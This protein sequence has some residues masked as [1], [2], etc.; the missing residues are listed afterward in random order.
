[1][2]EIPA[3][4]EAVK[5]KAQQLELIQKKY[6]GNQTLRLGVGRKRGKKREADCFEHSDIKFQFK[7]NSGISASISDL[8][9][10]WFMKTTQVLSQSKGAHCSPSLKH[11]HTLDHAMP[12]LREIQCL[13]SP[14]R[15]S[16][17]SLELLELWWG[18]LFHGK[19][20]Q[21]AV[22]VSLALFY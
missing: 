8:S 3:A 1:M 6:S 21:E 5:P 16:A 14:V 22:L 13:V 12:I 20:G 11:T 9:A 19:E 2:R 10:Q 4:S 18:D 7:G 17:L 15:G